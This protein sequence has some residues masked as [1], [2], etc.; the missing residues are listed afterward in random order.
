MNVISCEYDEENE[1]EGPEVDQSRNE[2]QSSLPPSIPSISACLRTN[3]PSRPYRPVLDNSQ[4]ENNSTPSNSWNNRPIQNSEQTST[5]N[6]KVNAATAQTSRS[7]N[8]KGGHLIQPWPQPAPVE[9]N[10]SQ[11]HDSQ[12][13]TRTVRNLLPNLRVYSNCGNGIRQEDLPTA[14]RRLRE[15]DSQ[16]KEQS[17]VTTIDISSTSLSTRTQT[18]PPRPIVNDESKL[19][20]LASVATVLENLPTSQQSQYSPRM[21]AQTEEK[22]ENQSAQQGRDNQQSSFNQQNRNNQQNRSTFNNVPQIKDEQENQPP[23]QPQPE[24]KNFGRK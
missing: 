3:I 24:K 17:S 23:P 19:R 12:G 10:A 8:A 16:N 21:F 13:R 4:N 6:P 5:A 15:L 11:N 18:L 2:T 7:E 9:V 1:R 14:V 22:Q 20:F